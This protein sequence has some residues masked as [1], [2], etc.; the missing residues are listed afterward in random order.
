MKAKDKGG[1]K[2]PRKHDPK[3]KDNTRA[4]RIQ[5]RRQRLNE[6][7]RAAGYANWSAYETAVINGK[8]I[9]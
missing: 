5:K 9:I 2:A 7:A 8:K 6:I 4:E 3:W 1:A